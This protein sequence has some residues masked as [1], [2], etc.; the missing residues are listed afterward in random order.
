VQILNINPPAAAAAEEETSSYA[1]CPSSQQQR[2]LFTGVFS[3]NFDLKN[4]ISTY[5]KDFLWEK[6][7]PP[8]SPDFEEFFFSNWPFFFMIPSSS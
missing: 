6:K 2:F 4:M 5:T 3:P 1:V 8:N 7:N